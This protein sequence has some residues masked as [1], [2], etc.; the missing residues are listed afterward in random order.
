MGAGRTQIARPWAR[1]IHIHGFDVPHRVLK[2]EL[3]HVF[4]GELA[5][6]PFRV[7]GTL[8]IFVN[9]GVVEGVA[10]AADWPASE[11]TVHGWTRAMRSLGLAPDMRRMMGPVGIWSVSSRR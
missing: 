9:I 7:P 8:G 3:A 1:Q 11:L 10:V 5:A 6:P 4:A 2:H